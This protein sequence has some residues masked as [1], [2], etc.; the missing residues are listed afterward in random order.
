MLKSTSWLKNLS[1]V[2]KARVGVEKLIR[3]HP[4]FYNR[5]E[6]AIERFRSADL[7]DRRKLAARRC[8]RAL[9]CARR[10]SYGR[11]RGVDFSSWPILEKATLR[12]KHAEFSA[13]A[14]PVV[15]ASTGG[16]TGQ[17]IK[18][19]RSIEC[20]AAEQ[21][22]I[23][24]VLGEEGGS[25]RESR[26]AV[27]RADEVKE[28]SDTQPP[29][30]IYRFNRRRLILSNAHLSESTI[31]WY[32]TAIAS[33]APKVLW[34]YPSMLANMLHLMER[35]D[36]RLK[37]P[38]VLCSSE[39]LGSELRNAIEG[40]LGAKVIDY[41]GQGERVCFAASERDSE[42]WFE[43]AYG[44]VEL[45][46]VDGGENTG[47]ARIIATAYWNRAMPL[48]RYDTGDVA[49]VPLCS[50]SDELEEIALGVKP[51]MGIEGRVNEYIV[52]RG[53]KCIAGLNHL[54]RGVDN[55][56]RLQVVQENYDAVAIRVLAKDGF[57]E[58][59]RKQLVE[60]ASKII[61]PEITL[62]V[63][64][65]DKLESTLNGKTPFIIRRV[66]E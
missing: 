37:I 44:Y 5:A 24:N 56:Y 33:F 25:F 51:F 48:I 14:F 34:V 42:Y 64:M 8:D 32:V 52:C 47:R 27:L 21:A 61:P 43:P 30:G 58:A 1:Q 39:S 40:T 19:R 16:T 10:T 66:A 18:L 11:N 54:P 15:S 60:N 59:N 9:E 29:Y 49:M 55:L 4:L 13:P 17:P 50:T 63:E 46:P 3:Y 31:N 35:N 36:L 53:G 28:L 38:I 62:S 20:V 7:G 23:D 2:A 12:D 41:Y 22:F 26:I 6:R 57:N 65:V 45:L